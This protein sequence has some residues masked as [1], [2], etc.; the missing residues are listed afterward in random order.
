MKKLVS[1]GAVAMMASSLFA[2]NVNVDYQHGHFKSV[3]DVDYNG[4]KAE[5][6]KKLDLLQDKNIYT[7]VGGAFSYGRLSA[8][9]VSD[10]DVYTYTVLARGGYNFNVE[11]GFVVTPYLQ[12]DYNLQH[13]SDDSFSVNVRGFGGGL[14]A[15]IGMNDYHFS[16]N[17]AYTYKYLD[18]SDVAKAIKERVINIGVGYSF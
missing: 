6:V 5:V 10:A 15:I 16:G 1:L 4:A 18:S 2:L 12:L 3:G 11:N 13:M 8:S 17:I 7:A 14:G 9:G